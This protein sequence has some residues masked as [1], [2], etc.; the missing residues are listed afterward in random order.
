MPL[1]MVGVA[2]Q[3]VIVCAA[4]CNLLP[5]LEKG[6]EKYFCFGDLRTTLKL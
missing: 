3:L 4:I 5:P 6:K 2:N 1:S